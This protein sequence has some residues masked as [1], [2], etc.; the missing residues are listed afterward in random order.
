MTELPFEDPRVKQNFALLMRHM[1]RFIGEPLSGDMIVT[2]QT[3]IED[4]RAKF[5]LDYGYEF[6]ALVPLILP[7]S[8]FIAWFRA[9]LDTHEIRL[10]L[11]NLLREF[12][13]KR[14]PI[15]EMEL[16]RAIKLAWPHYSPNIEEYQKAAHV[17]LLH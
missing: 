1:Q 16:A 8:Q 7:R 12:H 2:I 3:F 17:T 13:V 10:K 9:D 5:K 6:P 11:L 14:I 15:S 4:F